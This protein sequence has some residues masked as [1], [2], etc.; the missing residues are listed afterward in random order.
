MQAELASI[1]PGPDRRRF[2]LTCTRAALSR[3]PTIMRLG[4]RSFVAVAVAVTVLMTDAIRPATIRVEM[5]AMVVGLVAL[6]WLARRIPVLGPIA[7]GRTA[8]LVSLGGFTVIAAEVLIFISYARR[9]PGGEVNGD[10]A[11]AT[12]LIVIW[13]AML[14]IYVIA[15]VRMTAG[16]SRVATHTLATGAGIGAA[17]AA[18]WLTAAFADPSVPTSTG[19]AVVAIAAS[20]VCAAWVSRRRSGRGAQSQVAALCAAAGTALLIAV[21]I[22]GP[23]RLFSLWVANSA[24]PLY[25][26]TTA[27]RLVDSIGVWLLGSLLA[28]ALSLAIRPTR[29]SPQPAD[30]PNATVSVA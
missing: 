14:T 27:D 19:P 13:T 17:A 3:P 11:T 23:L 10:V 30:L 29:R 28:T 20:A 16:R 24:P 8:R 21:L 22:D 18:A 6:A 1:E 25:P 12:T 5:I 9:S 26:P 7:A 2:A 15:I 4:W